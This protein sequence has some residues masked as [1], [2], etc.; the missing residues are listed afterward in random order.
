MATHPHPSAPT[1]PIWRELS[2]FLR[3][4]AVLAPWGLRRAET[5]RALPVLVALHVAGL[6]LVILP[7]IAAWQKQFALPLP[8]A[9]GK[10]PQAWLLPIT[11]IAAPVIEETIFRGWQTGR[12]R[13]LWLLACFAAFVVLVMAARAIAPLVLAGLL[14]ALVAAVAAGWWRLRRWDTA[15][16]YRAAYPVVFW[17]VALLFAAVHLTNYPSASLLSAPMVLPQLWAAVLLGFTRQ[18]LGLPASILQHAMANAAS[19][20]LVAAG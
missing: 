8:D 17:I 19:M 14:L 5:W 11:V 3:R 4:P 6:L 16:A 13:A 20:A 1:I 2:A 7:L 10:L 9:F 15:P 12:P 18:R